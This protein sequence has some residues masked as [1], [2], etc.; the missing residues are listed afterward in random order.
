MLVY[1]ADALAVGAFYGSPT[2]LVDMVGV[3]Q[4]GAK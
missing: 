4:L 3:L 1:L 2:A